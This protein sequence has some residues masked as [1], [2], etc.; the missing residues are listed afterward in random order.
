MFLALPF[1]TGAGW[2]AAM[3]EA[4]GKPAMARV[5]T[6]LAFSFD[7]QIEGAPAASLLSSQKSAG[8][9]ESQVRTSPR[10]LPGFPWQGV[11]GFRWFGVNCGFEADVGL[12]PQSA[13]GLGKKC[14]EGCLSLVP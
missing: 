2:L 8:T 1:G 5:P 12:Q 10:M 13:S 7:T 6:S 4:E 14:L 3:R 11:R 9:I